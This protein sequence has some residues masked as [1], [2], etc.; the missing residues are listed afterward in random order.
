MPETQTSTRET[1]HIVTTREAR[2][3]LKALIEA[4]HVTII[5]RPSWRERIGDV[6]AL[7][8]PLALTRLDE[9][10]NRKARAR[11]RKQFTETLKALK[12]Q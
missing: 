1:A 11:A 7:I 2:A 3:H 10:A 6:R 5:T 4:G 12:L 8:V 9:S